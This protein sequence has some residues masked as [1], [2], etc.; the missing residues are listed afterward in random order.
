MYISLPL[1]HDYDWKMPNFTFYG[2]RKQVTTKYSFS[3]KLECGPKKSATGKLLYAYTRHL[4]RI[5]INA[6]QF[7]KNA[8]A[9]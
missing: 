9:F 8:N 1:L 7:E 3:F 4:Q 6:T 5:G 2:G